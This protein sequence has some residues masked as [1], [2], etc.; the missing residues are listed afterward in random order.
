MAIPDAKFIT[1]GKLRLW[2]ERFGHPGDPV[3]LLVMGTSTPGAGWPDAFVE[4]LV[5]GGRQVIRFDHR[6]TGRSD[7]VDFTADPYT[8]ADLAGDALAVLD[9]YGVEAAHVVGV[10]LGGAV[11]Q[12]LAVHRPGRVATLTVIMSSPMG[13]EA[14]PV[15]ERALSGRE[16]DPADLPPPAP[17][18]L[19]HLMRAAALPRTTRE[20]HLA[21]GL[22]TWRV[23]S[24]EAL[25]FDEEA[26]RRLVEESYDRAADPGAALNHD[27]AGRIMT[28]DRRAALSSV[29]A[30][31]LVVHG[32]EDPL[33]PLPHGA[34]VAAAIPH[35]RLEAVAGMGH[36]FLSPGLP[37]R[38]AELVL[39]HT[40]A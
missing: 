19:E 11:A 5:A 38:I 22:E 40:G 16:P 32:T 7:H 39:R 27:L 33:L 18:F 2:A 12:W 29:K 1:S 14:G 9:A 23:L 37:R 3:A 24:G 28:E 4:T 36:S 6:D 26:A 8:L 25:P 34:A 13:A 17:R 31:T 30:A 20:Q 15:W 21:A 10:S 35:A